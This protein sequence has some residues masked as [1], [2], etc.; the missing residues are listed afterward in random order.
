MRIRGIPAQGIVEE[1]ETA[2][3]EISQDPS[4]IAVWQP[5]LAKY[6]PTFIGECVKAIEWSKIMVTEWLTRNMF[7][8]DSDAQQNAESIVAALSSHPDTKTHS[9]HLSKEACAG[10]GLKIVNIEDDQK[11]QDLI[12][13]THHAFMHTFSQT[14]AVKI[15][16]ND[17]GKAYIQQAQMVAIPQIQAP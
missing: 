12:L 9:R 8:G 10:L 5:I 13:T 15:I 6:H 3:Q 17:A 7:A 16:E 14:A 2:K 1:F 4:R 11:L